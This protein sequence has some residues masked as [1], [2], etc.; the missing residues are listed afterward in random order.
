MLLEELTEL[1]QITVLKP[2]T[3]SLLV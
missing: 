3:T 1:D 2:T